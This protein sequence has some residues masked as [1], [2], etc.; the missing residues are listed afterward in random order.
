MSTAIDMKALMLEERAKRRAAK[1]AAAPGAKDVEAGEQ[2]QQQAALDAE[3][4]ALRAAR[5]A[6]AN[7]EGFTLA[8]TRIAPQ[9]LDSAFYIG[10]FLM[11]AEADVVLRCLDGP[12]YAAR[13]RGGGRRNLNLGGQPGELDIKE[14]LPDFALALIDALVASGAFPE[15]Q[16]P[17]HVL[18]NDYCDGHSGCVA[19]TDGP[20][21]SPRVGCLSLGGPALIE[22]WD[23]L[24]K[25]AREDESALVAGMLLR[26]CSLH[27]LADD[28][29]T[30]LFHQIRDTRRDVITEHV[31]NQ[32]AARCAAGDVVQRGERRLSIVFVH[33]IDES[34]DGM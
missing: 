8:S 21:Y 26:H 25:G 19:H 11:A 4:S 22:L 14:E 28:A 29:Y 31:V 10:D 9:R 33:K 30:N 5:C 17:N 3:G 2:R 18:V 7:R 23:D 20:L 6:I 27:V 24:A 16:R 13:W 34:E 32:A 1:A 12:R 15:A